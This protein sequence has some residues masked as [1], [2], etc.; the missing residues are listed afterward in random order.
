MET[1]NKKGITVDVTIVANIEKVWELWI[2]PHHIMHWNNAS[3]EWH[4]TYAK[5]DLRP[6]GT[7]LS[8]ME[9]RDGSVG[10]DF[11]GE[12]TWVEP[13][14]QLSY[15]LDDGRKVHVLFEPEGN[16]TVLTEIFEPETIHSPE[17]Q[18]AGWQAI[19]NN[20]KKYAEDY[21]RWETLHFE[22]TIDAPAER[23]YEN[24]LHD[25]HYREWTK[26][27]NP[28]SRYVGTWEKGSK[29]HF[30]GTGENGEEGGMVSFIK[31]NLYGQFVSIEHAG[32][33][34]K[35]EEIFDGPDVDKWKGFLENYTFKE[36]SGMTLLSIDTDT[37]PEYNDY[38]QKT[39]PGALQV[40]KEICEQ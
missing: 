16:K 31:E 3:D 25:Q 9:A 34:Q 8:R 6:G 35:G 2:G 18:R 30:L 22:I 5:N 23:V 11:S 14:K 36:V 15:V 33:L 4:T 24:M 29:I 12:Y 17:L 26:P 21:G 7:F 19:L 10:F 27:F 1:L 38:F 39:W 40:L 13:Y 32:I 28:T 20:F 37:P